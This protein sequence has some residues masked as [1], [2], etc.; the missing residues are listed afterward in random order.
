[1]PFCSEDKMAEYEFA[2]NQK[3]ITLK[4]LELKRW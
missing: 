4:K 1:M 2:K 3:D